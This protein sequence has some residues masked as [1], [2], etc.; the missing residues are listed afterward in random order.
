MAV[1]HFFLVNSPLIYILFSMA[2]CHCPTVRTV[3]ARIIRL[4]YCGKGEEEG[5]R[6]EEKERSEN[7]RQGCL[8]GFLMVFQEP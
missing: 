6:H 3:P 8:E 2:Q 4:L 7:A 5:K 1:L